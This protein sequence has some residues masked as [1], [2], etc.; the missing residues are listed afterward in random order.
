MIMSQLLLKKPKHIISF[1][2]YNNTTDICYY[3]SQFTAEE[4]KAQQ[5]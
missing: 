4:T 5:R 2:P 1:N 3:Y